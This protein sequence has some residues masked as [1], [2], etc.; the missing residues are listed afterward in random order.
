[1]PTAPDGQPLQG[2]DILTLDTFR[3]FELVLEWK[4]S[5]GGNSGIKYNVSEEMST[6]IPPTH[7]ALRFE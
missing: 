6:A 1:M 3:D 5:P 2:G 4:V 7:A